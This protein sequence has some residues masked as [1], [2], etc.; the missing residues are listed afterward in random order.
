[1]VGFA[2]DKP[3]ALGNVTITTHC[4]YASLFLT[5]SDKGKTLQD[6]STAI[7][8][9][10]S[11]NCNTGF[12]YS[13][14]DSAVIDNGKAPIMLEPVKADFI[15]AGRP[16]TAVNVLDQDGRV[17]DQ[18]LPVQN[19]AFTIDTGVQKTMYYQVVFGK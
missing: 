3:Q 6:D 17:T 19:G 10:V 14:L 7:I 8:C 16:I 1:M 5:A 15:I 18:T 4:P 2:P 12:R 9:A 13:A 11:R